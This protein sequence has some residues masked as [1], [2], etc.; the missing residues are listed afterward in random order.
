MKRRKKKKKIVI[1]VSFTI[2]SILAVA[3][4][5]LIL[6]PRHCDNLYS[7]FGAGK[8]DG[9]WAYIRHINCTD[10]ATV[11]LSTDYEKIIIH[12]PRKGIY[13]FKKNGKWGLSKVNYSEEEL[14]SII[15]PYEEI[16]IPATF[17]RREDVFSNAPA[18]Y[19]A[20]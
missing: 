9:K 19:R 20:K 17:D 13:Y 14:F 8:I 4:F 16:L 1:I 18:H 3:F 7:Y 2:L 10:D 15:S 5:F 11:I 12:S 6:S